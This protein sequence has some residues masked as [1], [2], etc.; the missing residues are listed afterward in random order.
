[1]INL[2]LSLSF[3]SKSLSSSV[4][5]A[6]YLELSLTWEDA[7]KHPNCLVLGYSGKMILRCPLHRYNKAT[8]N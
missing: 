4:K 6:T 3:D 5:L 7:N 2:I 1:M 8:V